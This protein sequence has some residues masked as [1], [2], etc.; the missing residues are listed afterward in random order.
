M[1]ELQMTK[2]R[3]FISIKIKLLGTL[4]PIIF[5][6][7]ITLIGLSYFVSKSVIKSDAHKLLQTSIESQASEIEAWLN[8]NLISL[9]MAKQTLEQMD[10][11]DKELQSF[12]DAYYNFD[13]NYPEGLYVADVKGSLFQSKP[14]KDVDLRKPNENGNYIN[15]GDFAE[16]ES[17]SDEEGWIFLTTLEGEASADIQDKTL[18]I[19]IINEGTVD[20]SI[21]LVQPGLPLQKGS[22]YQIQFDAYADANRAMA[23]R[24]TAPDR[25][26]QTYLNN[27]VVDLTP[28]KQTF[29]YSF[30]MTDYDDANGRMEFNLGASGS[31]AGIQISNVSLTMTNQPE[32]SST[33][34]NSTS[35][36]ITQTEWFQDGLTRVNMDFTNAYTNEGGKQ[37]ISACGMLRTH[38]DD[39]RILSADLSLDK[40]SVYVSSFIKMEDAE[41]FLIN[42][43]DGTILAARD[44]SLI[45]QKLS[46]SED[47]FMQGIA[48]KISKN[49]LGLTEMNGNIS[50]LEEVAGT[51][52]LL[53]SYVPT[54]TIYKDLNQLRNIMVLFGIISVLILMLLLERI[55]HI[56][57]R[58]VKRLTTV[59][60]LMTEG[61][62]TIYSESKSNDEIGIMSRCVNKFIDTMRSMIASIDNVSHT[63]HGQ[64]DNSNDVSNQLFQ[65][66]KRQNQSMK[67][68]NTTV[69]QLSISVSEVAQ[70]ATTLAALVEETKNDGD[71][72]NGKMKETIDISQKGKEIM[73]DVNASMQNINRSVQQLQ[74]AID[75]VGNA[76]EEITDITKVI[77]EIADETNLLSLNASIE[78]ARAG[79]AGKGFAVVATEI[80]KLAQTSMD[81][82]NHIDTLVLEIKKL[83]RDVIHLSKDNVENIN[84]SSVLIGNAVKTYDNIF[85][86]IITVG[87]LAQ[88]MM[89]KVNQV[90]NVAKDVATISEAQADSSQTILASSDILVEQT[91]NLM[92]NS[93]TVAKESKELTTSAEELETQIKT[94]KV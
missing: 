60:S 34:Q 89:Q 83:I 72:M 29:T 1:E 69:G 88:Q 40:I 58:P 78:A 39:I 20:Y 94:F 77:G 11:D 48:D 15:N 21:Q 57:I 18:S 31:I 76:S 86:N 85:E 63:L 55:V 44:T 47:V 54:Q 79:E 46:E 24:V 81:S 56:A 51:E 80:G 50:V 64:A 59:I 75:D 45:S 65:A 30:T 22:T 14:E 16:G 92:M 62:F 8:Q 84:N 27:T 23:I 93:E 41:S 6:I 90:E 33:S 71:G 91:D 49:E 38:S 12:L 7:V 37:V 68:L 87:D 5:A 74:Y 70:S 26:Y 82:V 67:E 9:S 19:G 53:M 3:K 32:S 36:D 66:S 25:D 17:L 35:S 52:W 28:E 43:E 61:D 73:W 10:F 13:S 2:K 4:L 42:A